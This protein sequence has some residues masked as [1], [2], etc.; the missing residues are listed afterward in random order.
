MGAPPFLT[1]FYSPRPRPSA[2]VRLHLVEQK[3]MVIIKKIGIYG[4]STNE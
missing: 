1:P 3:E 4:V 2:S